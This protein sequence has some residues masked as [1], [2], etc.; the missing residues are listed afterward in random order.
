MSGW[1]PKASKHIRDIETL[2]TDVQGLLGQVLL[3]LAAIWGFVRALRL[4]LR[5]GLIECEHGC[6]EV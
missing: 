2:L 1:R 6:G 3:T 4:V 5:R